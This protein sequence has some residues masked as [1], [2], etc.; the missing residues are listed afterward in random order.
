MEVGPL[1]TEVGGRVSPARGT[2]LQEL[3]ADLVVL[4]AVDPALFAQLHLEINHVFAQLSRSSCRRPAWSA[5]VVLNRDTS[6]LAYT[7]SCKR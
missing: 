7:S 5:S 2:Q 4:R 6:A 1:P 3:V